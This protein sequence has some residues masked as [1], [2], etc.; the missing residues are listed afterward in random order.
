MIDSTYNGWTNRETWLVNLW[1]GDDL[2]SLLAED[3]RR[4]DIDSHEA[5]ECEMLS[6]PPKAGLLSDF[7]ESCWS[8]VNWDEIAEA[9]TEGIQQETA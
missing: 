3:E 1:Y 4:T 5:E 9:L 6:Q 2:A 8:A 7:L